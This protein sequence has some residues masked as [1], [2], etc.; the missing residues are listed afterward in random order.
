MTVSPE[1]LDKN[2]NGIPDLLERDRE[3]ALP[4]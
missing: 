2:D 3:T 4:Y 1:R